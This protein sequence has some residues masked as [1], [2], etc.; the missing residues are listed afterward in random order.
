VVE[1]KENS[2][3]LTTWPLVVGGRERRRTFNV[4][5][6]KLAQMTREEMQADQ[7]WE[8]SLANKRRRQSVAI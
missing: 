1:E 7:D 3:P 6:Q 5:M 4:T 2:T 8:A